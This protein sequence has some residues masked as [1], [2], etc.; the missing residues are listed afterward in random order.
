MNTIEDLTQDQIREINRVKILNYI[1]NKETITKQRISKS[2]KLSIPTVTSVINQLIEDGFVSEAGV[3]KSTGGR[4]PVV[5]Q[6]EKNAKYSIGVNI[7]TD[8]IQVLLVNLAMEEIEDVN[9]TYNKALE[10]ERVL[11]KLKSKIR[12]IMKK[13]KIDKNQVIGMGISLPGIVEEDALVLQNAPNLN[14]RDFDF[15]SLKKELDIP[16]FIENEANVA[17]LAEVKL[18]NYKMA[19]HVVYISI[20]DGVGTGIVINHQI[21]KSINKKAGEFG[22]MRISNENKRCNCGRTGCWELYASK[23]ALYCII[24]AK[25]GKRIENIDDIVEE[26]LSNMDN[27]K[28]ALQ[29]YMDNVLIGIENIILA[30]NPEYV[31]I[32]GEMGKYEEALH[33]YIESTQNL[34]SSILEYEGTRIVFASLKDQ[35]AKMGAA[36]LPLETIFSAGKSVI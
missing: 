10:F 36:L 2:L 4:K 26:S 9:F 29:E 27:Y 35:G 7:M 22:H 13:N 34:K 12:V 8:R 1:K 14:I 3:A 6:F 32:G 21:F 30:L 25:T 23:E 33:K 18:G 17:A 19:R 15:N 11:E 20:T 24:E 31:I 5:L 16:L 28:D